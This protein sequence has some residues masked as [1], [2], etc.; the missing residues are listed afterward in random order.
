MSC[1]RLRNMLNA[2]E[3]AFGLW[4]SIADP[5]VVEIVAYAGFDYVNIDMEHTTLELATVENMCRAASASGISAL[6][7]VPE[8]NPKAILRIV[9]LGPDGIVVPQIRDAAD[10]RNAVRAAKY[11]PLGERGIKAATRAARY[12]ADASDFAAYAE[13]INSNLVIYAQIEDQGAIDDLEAIAAVDGIDVCGMGP[14]DLA[15]ALGCMGSKNDPKVGEAINQV[16]HTIRRVGKAK[17]GIP[18]NHSNYEFDAP[19]AIEL[20]A[21]MINCGNDVRAL[22]RGLSEN[23]ERAKA[24]L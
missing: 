9:E 7:R 24:R 13:R 18:I 15:R 19:S 23:I 12:G 5:A 6:V 20:G 10:A 8:N 11:A 16:A 22:T 3:P 21:V 1:L 4:V 2:G 17:L 14:A